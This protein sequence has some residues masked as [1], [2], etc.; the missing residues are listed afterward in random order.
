MMRGE[1]GES[2]FTLVEVMIVTAIVG[3]ASAIAVPNFSDWVSRYQL[4]QAMSEIAGDLNLAKL[5]AMNRNRQATVTIQ[6]VGGQ[7][8]VSGT[9]GGLDI[10]PTSN[11]MP[12]VNGL[13]SGTATVN[14]SSMGL[15]TVTAPQTIQVQN[16]KGLVYSLSVLPSGKVTWCATATCP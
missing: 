10:F 6:M 15:N 5:T 3:I 9:S 13:P 2:G 16:E 11:L 1:S 7:V 8:Q 12:R 4:K 14:F